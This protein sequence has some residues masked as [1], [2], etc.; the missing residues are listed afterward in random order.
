MVYR[1]LARM[2]ESKQRAL[3]QRGEILLAR[4]DAGDAL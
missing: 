2:A 4:L 1:N 3:W